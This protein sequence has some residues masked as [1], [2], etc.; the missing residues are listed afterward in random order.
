SLR[1]YNRIYGLSYGAINLIQHNTYSNYNGL[2]FLAS[3][4]VGHVNF[5]TSYTFSKALGIRGINGV[6]GGLADNNLGLGRERA[7]GVLGLDRTHV[8][9]LAY[10]VDLPSI[11][12]SL[13]HGNPVAKGFLDGWQ[14]TGISQ[15][16]AGPPIQA[17]SPNFGLTYKFTG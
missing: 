5:S 7:Y 4:Q 10:V 11:G 1:N 6:G 9:S 12:N 2:H 16:A 13:L 17:Y 8:F 15:W 3:R 14:L